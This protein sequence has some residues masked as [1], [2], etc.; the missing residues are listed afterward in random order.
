[1]A[2]ALN[3]APVASHGLPVSRWKPALKLR[4]VRELW[5]KIRAVFPSTAL[6]EPAERLLVILDRKEA[7]LVVKLQLVD[8]VRAEWALLCAEVIQLC[9]EKAVQAFWGMRQSLKRREWS[10]T[11][12]V[13]R[14]VWT[15]FVEKWKDDQ[16]NWE[17]AIVLLSAPFL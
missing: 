8:E 12:G 2:D 10:W 16:S 3:T 5:G 4:L 9:D 17:S 7:N 15:Q 13:K 11:D 14:M 1:M 6:A